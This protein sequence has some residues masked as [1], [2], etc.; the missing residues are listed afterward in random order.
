MHRIL[1]KVTDIQKLSIK[2]IV[3]LNLPFLGSLKILSREENQHIK[4][5]FEVSSVILTALHRVKFA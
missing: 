5:S 3:I 4:W 2:G 1:V